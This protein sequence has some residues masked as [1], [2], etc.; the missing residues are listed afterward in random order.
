[1]SEPTAV[2]EQ[3]ASSSATAVPLDSSSEAITPDEKLAV[4][5][6]LATARAKKDTGDAAFKSGDLK[7]ALRSYHEA[8]MYLHGIDKNALKS[9]G[10]A[11][12]SRLPTSAVDEAASAREEK[13]EVDTMLERIYANM[14]ACHLKNQNW[15]RALDT[16]DKAI[17]KNPANSKALFRKAKALGELG[18]FE[19]AEGVL[20]EVKKIAPN[21]APMVDAELSRQRTAD[22][23]R[24]RVH[25]Q[26]MRGWLSRDKRTEAGA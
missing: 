24:Q 4:E 14:S 26:K 2:S 5:S 6:K 20:A 11:S 15:K 23:E 12:P 10:M 16:A 21:E 7:S 19:K 8:L 22:K 17:A 3:I 18:Y 9:L 1:M 25:D 13:T